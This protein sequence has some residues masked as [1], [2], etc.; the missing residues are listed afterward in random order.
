MLT[1]GPP[2]GTQKF[3]CAGADFLD[4][5]QE[6]NR[7]SFPVKE[8]WKDQKWEVGWGGMR[9][10]SGNT[11]VHGDSRCLWNLVKVPFA[12]THLPFMTQDGE[13]FDKGAENLKT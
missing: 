11:E 1:L 8:R 7:K 3:S 13:L 6:Q 2:L 5:L 4:K 12:L 9:N 10:T